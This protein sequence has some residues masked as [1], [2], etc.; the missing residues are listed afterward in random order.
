MC[1][2]YVH[3]PASGQDVTTHVAIGFLV[4]EERDSCTRVRDEH[5]EVLETCGADAHQ[6]AW[7][8]AR[9]VEARFGR[10]TAMVEMPLADPP[11]D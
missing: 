7:Q 8:W 5:D 2:V 6:A 3:V 9:A 11:K 4:D 1:D 10:V